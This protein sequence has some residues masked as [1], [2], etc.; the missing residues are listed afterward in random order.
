MHSLFSPEE[1]TDQLNF[2]F[3]AFCPYFFKCFCLLI[4]RHHSCSGIVYA[5]I[6]KKKKKKIFI[7]CMMVS[8]RKSSLILCSVKKSCHVK[9]CAPG[10]QNCNETVPSL[11]LR[12]LLMN[13]QDSK[14]PFLLEDLLTGGWI[15]GRNFV[16]KHLGIVKQQVYQKTKK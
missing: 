14:R 3:E 1:F 10:H 16:R 15:T 11:I 5:L 8:S 6:K 9:F 13:F 7:K 2:Y 4:C 12:L